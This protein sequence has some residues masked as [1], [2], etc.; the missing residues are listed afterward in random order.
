MSFQGFFDSQSLSKVRSYIETASADKVILSTGFFRDFKCSLHC[1][2]CCKSVNLEYLKDTDRWERFKSNYQELVPLFKEKEEGVMS[3]DNK[4]QDKYCNFLDRENGSCMIHDSAP[5]PCRFAP[6][7]FIDKRVSS[8][9]SYLNASAY[10]RA[11]AFTQ[12]D[13]TKGTKCEV[14]ESFNYDKFLN[15]LEMI[16]ELHDYAKK[17]N[18]KSKL[19]YII[20]FLES[21]KESFK[22]GILPKESILF[23]QENIL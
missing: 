6:L 20:D 21:G 13:G 4:S 11:W 23:E 15:D 22:Q 19:S 8:N 2:A 5:L 3:F 1:G 7:K 18:L 10:G 17:L 14:V 9:T 16:K 12:L